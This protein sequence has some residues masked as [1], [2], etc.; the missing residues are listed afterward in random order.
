[1]F[2]GGLDYNISNDTVIF[3]HSMSPDQR[4]K[5]VTI[6][7]DIIDDTVDED[8]Q[9]FFLSLE[10]VSATNYDRLNVISSLLRINIDDNDSEY[11]Y[12]THARTQARTHART[13]TPRTHARTHARTHTSLL[14][15]SID[16]NDSE[17]FYYFVL[18]HLSN[19][20]TLFYVSYFFPSIL[21]CNTIN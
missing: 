21:K 15:I 8:E 2:S 5:Y 3:P 9:H 14:R 16:D 13:H 4:T 11:F 12:H 6:P 7:L 18:F 1:M 17:Y 19:I 10:V 20:P